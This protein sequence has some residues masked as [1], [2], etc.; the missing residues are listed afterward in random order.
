MA[1]FSRPLQPG[2]YLNVSDVVKVYVFV[3][4]KNQVAD[5]FFYTQTMKYQYVHSF[6]KMFVPHYQN[7]YGSQYIIFDGFMFYKA[8]QAIITLKKYHMIA[9]DQPTERCYDGKEDANTSSC[10]ANYVEKHLGCNPKILGSSSVS[11]RFC[12]TTYQL[13]CLANITNKMMTFNVNKFYDTT[14][15][16]ASCEKDEYETLIGKKIS[17]GNRQTKDFHIMFNIRSGSYEEK[18]QYLSYDLDSFIADFGGF[19][20]LLLGWSVFSLYNEIVDL[21]VKFKTAIYRR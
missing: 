3:S 8:Y 13:K 15:C 20:G 19:L 5:V 1:L 16:L 2:M 14:K 6:L 17:H 18:E 11:K 12:N 7:V 4:N 10:I 21:A 9:L